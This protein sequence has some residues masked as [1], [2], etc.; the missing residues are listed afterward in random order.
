MQNL[1][2]TTLTA[3]EGKKGTEYVIT[4]PEG[5]TFRDGDTHAVR[6]AK[7]GIAVAVVAIDKEDGAVSL[8]TTSARM[9]L[10]RKHWLITEGHV[11]DVHFITLSN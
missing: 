8:V 10:A 2:N 3:R 11:E 1:A 5:V 9:E 6:T 7:R 4:L